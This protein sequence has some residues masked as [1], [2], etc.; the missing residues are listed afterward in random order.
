MKCCNCN[1]EN[2]PNARFCQHCGTPL[3]TEP[4]RAKAAAEKRIPD[5]SVSARRKARLF[6]LLQLLLYLMIV[7]GTLLFLFFEKGVRVQSAFRED[8][9][10]EISLYSV[11]GNLVT[12]GEKYNPT[13]LSIVMGV[14]AILLAFSSAFFWM[15][16]FITKSIG[17][18]H[19]ESHVMTLIIT[20]LNLAA[21]CLLLPLAYRY[22]GVLK[23]I[24]ARAANFPVSEVSA[25]GSVWT[26]V[27]SGTILLLIV[28]ELI[29]ASKEKKYR[30]QYQK[31]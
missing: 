4:P 31:G 30:K 29:F 24:C 22:S 23:Q 26:F 15:V 13:A 2:I 12:G 17:K 19:K 11:M 27:F 9:Y 6:L 3:S 7:A 28:A 14:S 20:A 5:A 21:V 16:T 1:F 10:Q 25:V 18:F 8:A